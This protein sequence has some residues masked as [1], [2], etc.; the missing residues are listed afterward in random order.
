MIPTNHVQ[1]IQ[2]LYG[3]FT[4]TERVVQKIWLR[5]DFATQQLQTA[6]GETLSVKDPGRWNLLGGPDF[7]EA[8]LVIGGRELTGDVEVHF[9]TSDWYAHQ[10]ER[11]PEFDRVILHVVLHPEKGEPRSVQTSHGAEP[12]LLCLMPLLNRDLEAYAMDDAL[13][14]L[15]QVDEL[16]WVARFLEQPAEARLEQITECAKVRWEQKLVYAQKRLSDAG[17]KESCHQLCLEV[18]GYARNREAMSRVALQYPLSD[19]TQGAVDP[20]ECFKQ[21]T[22][23]W[24]LGGV[25]PVNHPRRRLEQYAAIAGAHGDWTK[26]VSLTLRTLATVEGELRTPEFRKAIGLSRLRDSLRNG[27]FIGELG[28]KRFNTLMIDALLPLAHTAG[29]FDAVPYWMHWPMGDMPTSLNR[30]LKQADLLSKQQPLCN[31]LAQGALAL[32]LS[33][34][35]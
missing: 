35:K 23:C 34:G 29:L 31:G 14:E 33:G 21:F 27:I 5:Q 7:K 26:T 25:R 15:E 17:W 18:L 10:H 11:N 3:P 22:S 4:L 24:K 30:F 12:Y 16:E 32:F 8:R 13:L 20:D 1:E 6:S 9:T 19:W 28:E 2:G